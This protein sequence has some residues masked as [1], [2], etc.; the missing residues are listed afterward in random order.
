MT[1]WSQ[2]KSKPT[3][4]R[5]DWRAAHDKLEGKLDQSDQQILGWLAA[6]KSTPAI[7]Q[8]LCT[9]RSAI[10]RRVERIKAKLRDLESE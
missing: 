7:A 3:K 9:N 10:W 5:I 4:P 6:G 8:M 1:E 2:N